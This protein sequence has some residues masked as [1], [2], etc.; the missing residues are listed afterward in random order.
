MV[1]CFAVV[2]AR[3]TGSH[4]K[5]AFCCGSGLSRLKAL[6]LC[7]MKRCLEKAVSDNVRSYGF[8]AVLKEPVHENDRDEICDKLFRNNSTLDLNI[9]GT[10]VYCDFNR[11]RSLRERENIYGLFIGTVNDMDAGLFFMNCRRAGLNIDVATIKPYN[12]IWYNGADSDMS[13]LTKNEFMAHFKK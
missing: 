8:I 13:M 2:T 1:H 6:I 12:C 9:E 4:G 10:L 5:S 3:C 7:G 11:T